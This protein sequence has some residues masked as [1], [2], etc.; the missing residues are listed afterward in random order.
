MTGYWSLIVPEASKNYLPNPSAE[1]D[2]TGFTG[3]A[4]GTAAGTRTRSTAWA[5]RGIYGY[6][7]EKTG[8]GASDHWGIS[9]NCN[10][11]SDFIAGTFATFS[12][13][14]YVPSGTTVTIQ[15][16]INAPAPQTQ[17]LQIV[18][19][20]EGRYEV[21]RAN[22][23]A[24]ASSVVAYVYIS[25]ATGSCYVDGWQVEKK[26]YATTY[27]DGDLEGCYWDGK[28]HGSTSQRKATTRSG[29]R[30]RNL[31]DYD[32]SVSES[33]GDGMV[34]L[35]LLSEQ[36]PLGAGTL[37]RGINIPERQLNLMLFYQ[38]T[39]RANLHA[40][41][42]TLLDLLKP[43][44]V[45]QNQP[46]LLRYSGG[47]E[48]L[49]T[50]VRYADGLNKNAFD[51]FSENPAVRLVANDPFWYKEAGTVQALTT[52]STISVYY[53]AAK[54][55]GQWQGFTSSLG[56]RVRTLLRHLDGKLWIGGDFTNGA[57][58]AAADYIMTYENGT[59]AA[60][61][62]GANGNVLCMA[63]AANG[64]VY[65]GGQFTAMG[66][67][68]N[69]AY[70]AKWDYSAGA[71]VSVGNANGNVVALAVA[72]DGTVYAAGEFT[73]IGGVACTRIAKWN[74]S[75]WS[76]MGTGANG[77]VNALAVTKD[78]SVYLGGNFTAVG[79]VSNTA[80][81]ARWDG[82]AWNALGTGANGNV[83]SLSAAP[84]GDLILGGSFTTLSGE[85]IPYIGRW[86]GTSFAGLGTGMDNTVFSVHA[87]ED[88]RV[89]A[90]GTFVTA[91]GISN[92]NCFAEWNGYTWS[93]SDIRFT[94]GG[95][96]QVDAIETYEDNIYLGCAVTDTPYVSSIN[97][98]SHDGSTTAYPVITII[99][100]NNPTYVRWLKN[101]TSGATMWLNYTL[102]PEEK[103]VLDFRPGNRSVRS[104]VHGLLWSGVLR[105]SKFGDFNLLSGDNSIALMCYD[106]YAGNP[107]AVC[108]WNETYW[109]AD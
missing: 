16:T 34:P 44:L 52:D 30:V 14:L 91:G 106:L 59:Y 67:V 45:P 48:E 2:A 94:T 27:L 105:N 73:T 82:S 20:A 64:D 15:I 33:V 17:T 84:N 41:R 107:V 50:Q 4:S 108:Q 60:L 54:I 78:G 53:L 37:F 92:V 28:V 76:A 47:A 40:V 5:T 99:A 63:M 102:Q 100:G 22:S 26:S 70:I 61:G 98:V 25:S 88:G 65:V 56:A 87:T 35:G 6:Y 77:K 31:S 80:Y 38:G 109:S 85:T 62:T 96:F 12:V 81:V 3:Y 39:S 66:G 21:S 90:G 72:P 13:D 36:L 79:G 23:L 95:G 83:Q 75:A 49:Q 57:G 101:E 51:G 93:H 7:L 24:P 104:S 89:F 46:I 1:V 55:R 103:L 58:I 18:G 19:P 29:G 32:I 9:Q 8:G 74:G 86:N 68:A 97:T 11:P 42:R 43:D 10:D 69:T 71:W